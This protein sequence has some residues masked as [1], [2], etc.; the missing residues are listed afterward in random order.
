NTEYYSSSCLGLVKLLNLENEFMRNFTL[1]TDALQEKVNTLNLYLDFLKRPKH[2][3]QKEREKFVSNPLNAFG[4]MRRLHQDWPKLQNY[5]FSPVGMDILDQMAAIVMKG[6]GVYDMN[7]AQKSISRIET[8]YDLKVNDLAKGIIYNKKYGSQM[9]FRDYFSLALQ[10]FESGNYKRSIEWLQEAQQHKSLENQNATKQI[11]GDPWEEFARSIIIHN[12]SLSN[13]SLN[14]E[15]IYKEAS[16]KLKFSKSKEIE[17]DI[18]LMLNQW[19]NKNHIATNT[20]EP[21]IMAHYSGCRDQFPKQKNLVCRYNTTTSPFLKLA[22]LKLEEVNLDPYIVL[23]HNVIS[24]EEIDEMKGLIDTFYNGWTD[25]DESKEIIS[26]LVWLT[27]E[28]SFRKRLNLRI[29]D[30]TGFMVDEIPGLQIANYGV[31]GYF[32]PHHDY[33]TER[34]LKYNITELGDR[35]ASII[36]Y[37]GD[38]VHGGQTVFPDIQISVK[39]QK[40]SCLV[41]FNTFD[42]ATPDPRSLHSVC[43]VLVG[44][45]WSKYNTLILHIFQSDKYILAVTKWLHYE[46]QLFVKPCLQRSENK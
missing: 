37:A 5:V 31:G 29:R 44:D 40:G 15:T 30:I 21:S 4:L 10:N 33:F 32:K 39:P 1:Y 23:Y 8:T 38:V 2:S 26:R 36:F 34:I 11:L 14:N 9:G 17:E 35:M 45:R 20:T 42:D 12:I 22:P 46:P 7:E 41:W 19:N 25:F 18:N 24:D 16:K 3:T 13:P 28:S 6:P 27:E 43:P